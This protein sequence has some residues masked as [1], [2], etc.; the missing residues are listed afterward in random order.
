MTVARRCRIRGT[1]RFNEGLPESVCPMEMTPRD[2]WLALLNRNS[3][4]R[5]P[6][7][8]QAT[9]GVTARLCRDL[10]C[11]DGGRCRPRVRES[12][13]IYRDARWICG[14]CQ[15]LQPNTPTE[16]IVA[17]YETIHQSGAA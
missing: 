1:F 16:N 13:A 14:P 2:R 3:P 17:M 10:G 12:V 15:N 8:Y 6:T 5:I 9:D 7:D 11:T 4:D